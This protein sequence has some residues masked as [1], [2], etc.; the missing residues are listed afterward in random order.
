MCRLSSLTREQPKSV[1]DPTPCL[2]I[3]LSAFLRSSLAVLLVAV[4]KFPSRLFCPRTSVISRLRL[5][6]LAHVGLYHGH[7]AL[8]PFAHLVPRG[9][10]PSADGGRSA[11]TVP[12]SL[13][14]LVFLSVLSSTVSA[15]VLNS[16]PYCTFSRLPSAAPPSSSR[17][18]F[19]FRA[20]RLALTFGLA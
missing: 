6:Y 10:A 20:A 18:R 17:F 1:C 3:V 15:Y 11:G 4:L 12:A 9:P 16:P 19:V 5:G 2:R 13:F 14:F 8:P 7:W